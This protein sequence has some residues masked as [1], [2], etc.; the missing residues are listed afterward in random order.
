MKKTILLIVLAL[1]LN[2]SF[3]INN[4]VSQWVQ[5]SGPT[6]GIVQCFAVSGTNIF[7][8]TDGG[9][10]FLSTN[11]GSNWTAVNNGLTNLTVYTLV[12]SGI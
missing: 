5:T 10:V 9:G 4:C 3:L 12:F 7:A 1:I 2:F 6:G 11:N 8:G